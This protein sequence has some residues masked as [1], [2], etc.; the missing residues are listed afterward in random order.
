M[1]SGA[2]PRLGVS[3]KVLEKVRRAGVTR[4][5]GV[6]GSTVYAGN[7]T[8]RWLWAPPGLALPQTVGVRQWGSGMGRGPMGSSCL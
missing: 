8:C 1:Y 6:L 3:R 7:S 5:R 2:W 4:E